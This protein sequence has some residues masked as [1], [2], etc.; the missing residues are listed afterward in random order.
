MNPVTNPGMAT[1]DE[2]PKKNFIV[3]VNEECRLCGCVLRIN[4]KMK[5]CINLFKL[6]KGTT[7]TYGDRL[8][9]LIKYPVKDEPN[10]SRHL[11]KSCRRKVDNYEQVN[12]C[13]EKWRKTIITST[14][15]GSCV[16]E[17]VKRGQST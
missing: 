15:S 14:A 11:C 16:D 12:D 8:S 5:S 13:L 3:Q 10:Q 9:V 1:S 17:R 2:T 4:G 6:G 7:K